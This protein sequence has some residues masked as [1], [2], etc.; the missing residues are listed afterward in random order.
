MKLRFSDQ[1][2]RLRLSRPEVARLAGEGRLSERLTFPA[3]QTLEYSV[4]TGPALAV[5]FDSARLAITLPAGEARNWAQGDAVAISGASGPLKISVE[6]DF[7]CLHGP[8]SENADAFPN[9]AARR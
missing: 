3:G 1:S 7:Q 2:V 8:E 4:E 9:P 5:S 6:K